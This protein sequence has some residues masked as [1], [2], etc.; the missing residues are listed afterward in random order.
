MAKSK[1]SWGGG[2]FLV[3]FFSIQVLLSEEF[4]GEMMHIESDFINVMRYILAGIGNC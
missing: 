4:G 2:I 3:E 1:G